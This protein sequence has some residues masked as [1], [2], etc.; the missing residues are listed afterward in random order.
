MVT[1]LLKERQGN[2]NTNYE[3]NCQG[4]CMLS[5]QNLDG[6]ERQPFSRTLQWQRCDKEWSPWW[7]TEWKVPVLLLRTTALWKPYSGKTHGHSPVSLRNKPQLES[8]PAEEGRHFAVCFR[9]CT[10]A[11]E[12]R[13]TQ[14][15]LWTPALTHSK[16]FTDQARILRG[17]TSGVLS[18]RRASQ[19]QNNPRAG[20]LTWSQP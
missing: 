13:E 8:H 14:K 11:V 3:W 19:T 17:R 4:N 6:Y 7:A 2:L 15:K 20:K 9:M 18:S 10:R 1:L 12:N 16:H 5:Q